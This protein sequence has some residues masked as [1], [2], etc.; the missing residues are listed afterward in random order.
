MNP[1]RL[2]FFSPHDPRDVTKLSGWPSSL[3]TVLT[4]NSA[5]N[6]FSMEIAW[7][8]G[9][10]RLL[11]LVARVVNRAFRQFGF[12]IN[13]C[14]S[15][16]YAMIAGC[17]LTIRLLFA[18][19]GAVLAVAA[20]NYMPYVITKREIIY[21]S[22]ATF[23]AICD[24]Y[25]AFKSFPKWL[26]AQGH[27]NEMK[28]LAGA[29]FALYPSQWACDSARLDYKVPIDKIYQLPFGPSIPDNLID[30]HYTTKFIAS[31]QEIVVIFVSADWTRKNGNKAIDV[32]RLLIEAGLRTRLILIGSV[33]EYARHLDFVDYRGFLRKSD[34]THLVELCRAYRESHFLLVPTTA[35]AFGIVFSEAQAFGV[36]PV[37]HDVGGTGS[38]I[39]PDK[40]G[41]LLPL[42]APPEMFAKKILQYVYDPELYG[43][44]SQRCREQYLQRANWRQWSAL[45]FQLSRQPSQSVPFARSM[46]SLGTGERSSE[47]DAAANAAYGRRV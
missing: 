7:I 36:P 21:I 27:R 11:N 44:L 24:L 3:F 35:E 42:G 10:L 41:L 31:A 45:I 6:P 40:T 4:D 25:P 46:T 38:A 17:Y 9:G 47:S 33:P 20:S 13:C 18:R 37:A 14:Y 2:I 8:G 22:D 34:P 19:K 32:C 5:H 30:Q 1:H 23:H 43:E 16:P 26:M 29:Q 28:T 15:T 12:S 39:V